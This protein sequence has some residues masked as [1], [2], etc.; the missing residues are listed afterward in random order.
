MNN[1]QVFSSHNPLSMA[2]RELV[3]DFLVEELAEFGDPKEAVLKCLNFA[4]ADPSGLGGLVILVGDFSNLDGAL[5]LNKTGMS[6][7]IPENIL[8]YF[9]VSK[10]KRGQGLGK[11]MLDFL[12]GQIE[13]SI[14]L[15]VEPNN[16]AKALYE[17]LGFTNKY[18]EMRLT[19]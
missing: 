19:R 16:P 18:L 7:Y 10:D 11:A 1:F 2:Q 3:A 17:R 14:A 4:M 15:H 9:A 13:G 8:V 5:V 6:E 12:L